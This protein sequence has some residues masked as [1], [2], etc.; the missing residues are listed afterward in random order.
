MPDASYAPLRSFVS[1]NGGLRLAAAGSL[2]DRL[3]TMAVEECPVDAEAD[4]GAEVLAARM[5]RRLRNQYGSVVAFL[6]ISILA[7]LIARLVW[8]WFIEKHSHR[9]LMHG[10]QRRAKED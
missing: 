9:V 5:R 8:R 6:A 4:V 2:R 3:L 1:R 10:W 7:N